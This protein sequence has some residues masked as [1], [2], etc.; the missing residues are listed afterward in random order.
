MFHRCANSGPLHKEKL[1][2]ILTA[3]LVIDV[4]AVV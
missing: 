1:G 4:L 3:Q 2:E